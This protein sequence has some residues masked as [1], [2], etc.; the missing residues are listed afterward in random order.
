[1][2][3]IDL[4]IC[5]LF[6]CVWMGSDL[7]WYSDV[8]DLLNGKGGLICSLLVEYGCVVLFFFFGFLL[9]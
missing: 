5:F 1:M 7:C 4:F 2:L 9:L 8:N 3:K 6:R